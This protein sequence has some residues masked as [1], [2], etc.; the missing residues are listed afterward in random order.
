MSELSGA[1]C[2]DLYPTTTVEHDI[3]ISNKCNLYP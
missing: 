3:V 1:A 2:I